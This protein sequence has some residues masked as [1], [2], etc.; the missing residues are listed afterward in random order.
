MQVFV[1]LW[2]KFACAS[3]LITTTSYDG[4]TTGNSILQFILSCWD[5]RAC[6][7][8]SACKETL[9]RLLCNSVCEGTNTHLYDNF[10]FTMSKD[11]HTDTIHFPFINWCGNVGLGRSDFSSPLGGGG[12]VCFTDGRR[13]L[14]APVRGFLGVAHPKQCIRRD[15]R[16]SIY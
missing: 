4:I 3:W 9:A 10:I 6:V 5:V 15:K 12:T 13:R 16:L 1:D 11:S 2:E 8:V 7:C 14:L